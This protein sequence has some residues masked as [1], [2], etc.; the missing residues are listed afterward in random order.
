[1]KGKTLLLLLVLSLVL[2]MVAQDRISYAA[3]EFMQCI[4][5]QYSKNYLNI[6]AMGRGN[7]GT[8][9]QEGLENAGANPAGFTAECTAVHFEFIHKN[10][11]REMN[12][13]EFRQNDA[14]FTYETRKR[15]TYQSTNPIAY[16][17]VGFRVVDG[18]SAGFSYGMTQS[19][20]YED[21]TREMSDD[22]YYILSPSYTASRLSLTTSYAFKQLRAGLN[23]HYCIY[24][25]DDYRYYYQN[26]RTD[27]TETLF[28][29]QPGIQYDLKHFTIGA[30]YTPKASHTFDLDNE[31][32]Y[33]VT[34]PS[35]LSGGVVFRMK[36]FRASGDVEYERCSEQ[37][38]DFDDRIRWKAGIEFDYLYS[39]LRLG[40][41]YVP[42]VFAGE[43]EYPDG[44][45]G[46]NQ[47]PYYPAE[48]YDYGRIGDS[49]QAFLTAGFTM[50]SA[51]GDFSFGIMT[52][53]IG[54]VPVTMGMIGITLDSERMPTPRRGHKE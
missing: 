36:D 28:R 5:D 7:T 22:S 3:P 15:Q 21:F 30:S 38:S 19:I 39:T 31:E 32:R 49:D 14:I 48:G 45:Y 46:G 20:E 37:S 53:I 54:D 25:L 12:E 44:G 43:Y 9:F 10:N 11:V 4:Y 1:M 51:L 13:I 35:V 33:D 47:N 8:A 16:A 41:M 34:F 24:Q 40:F 29:F 26:N 50:R 6:N 52:D 23:I 42:G 2:Q 18:L 27:A 17:G